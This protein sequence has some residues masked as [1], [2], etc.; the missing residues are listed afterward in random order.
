[1]KMGNPALTCTAT[2]VQAVNSYDYPLTHTPL[3][4][5]AH[6]AFISHVRLAKMEL[7]DEAFDDIASIWSEDTPTMGIREEVSQQS[8]S[9]TEDIPDLADE[10]DLLCDS[11]VNLDVERLATRPVLGVFESG[12]YLMLLGTTA[13]LV[14][15]RGLPATSHCPL[16]QLFASISPHQITF[17][18][19]LFLYLRAF[20]ADIQFDGSRSRLN[21]SGRTILLGVVSVSDETLEYDSHNLGQGTSRILA[22]LRETGLLSIRDGR[23][24]PPK[25]ELSV[26]FVN[27][28]YCD[29][30]KAHYWYDY[31]SSNHTLTCGITRHRPQLL[32]LVDCRTHRIVQPSSWVEYAALSYVWAAP[33]RGKLR[34]LV[35]DWIIGDVLHNLPKTI[36][37]SMD[38]AKSL[39]LQYSWIGKYC[40]DQQNSE[41]KTHQIRQMDAI[42]KCAAM[43]IIAAAGHDPNYGLPGINGTVR[44]TQ[45][46]VRIGNHFVVQTLPHPSVSLSRSRWASRGW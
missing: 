14:P 4:Q 16:C 46:A 32:R 26:Q 7:C 17:P 2:D 35:D 27:P 28:N 25:D 13:M 42:Y 20:S 15:S 21:P 29:L 23:L 38:V 24:T 5:I 10:Q 9:F 22:S 6:D 11:C 33:D 8:E 45:K 40:I 37:D 30:E 41:D 12:R 44:S 34:D 3:Y 18:S 36:V 31:C 19:D 1:M 39:N 43:T